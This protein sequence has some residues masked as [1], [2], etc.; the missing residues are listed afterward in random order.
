MNNKAKIKNIYH[1]K[2]TNKND[3]S[4]DRRVKAIISWKGYRIECPVPEGTRYYPII[5]FKNDDVLLDTNTWSAD[6][7]TGITDELGVCEIMI[8]Y[9]S[10]IAPSYNM[11]KGR[12]FLLFEGEKLVATGKIL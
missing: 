8:R 3:F 1:P 6:I 7:I 2:K 9:L 10:I 11:K 12:S 4:Q 5:R